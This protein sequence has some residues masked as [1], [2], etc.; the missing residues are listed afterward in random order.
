[1]GIQ[2]KK[3]SVLNKHS[4]V[5]SKI[6]W[7]YTYVQYV[8]IYSLKD[9]PSLKP[10]S[11]QILIMGLPLWDWMLMFILNK[12][13]LFISRTISSLLFLN[14]A[15]WRAVTFL[16]S[17]NPG[18]VPLSKNVILSLFFFIFFFYLSLNFRNIWDF[19]KLKGPENKDY[20]YIF[21]LNHILRLS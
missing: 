10:F 21:N 12:N 16:L 15:R 13:Y 20:S 2:R 1:M 3:E 11:V 8:H 18:S 6:L 9:I 4:I 5:P 17:L 14:A 7:Y 19:I